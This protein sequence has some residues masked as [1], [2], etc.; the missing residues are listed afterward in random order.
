[1]VYNIFSHAYH[2]VKNPQAKLELETYNKEEDNERI[3]EV[4]TLLEV[5]I[6]LSSNAGVIEYLNKLSPSHSQLPKKN[7]NENEN[8]NAYI[9][10]L[11]KDK[12]VEFLSYWEKSDNWEGVKNKLEKSGL[13]K[14]EFLDSKNSIKDI[15]VVN[16][17]GNSV[18]L[19]KV[20]EIIFDRRNQLHKKNNDD[21][22]GFIGVIFIED[23][24]REETVKKVIE[25]LQTADKKFT[26][27]DMSKKEITIQ[28]VPNSR[29][30]KE[31][32]DL[33]GNNNEIEATIQAYIENALHF[34]SGDVR[35]D[36]PEGKEAEEELIKMLQSIGKDY[37]ITTNGNGI[38]KSYAIRVTNGNGDIS[39]AEENHHSEKEE[40]FKNL[41]KRYNEN[42]K[43]KK[44]T[45][46]DQ[47]T[48]N[49]A[50]ADNILVVIKNGKIEVEDTEIEE[51]NKIFEA[52]GKE[53]YFK[54]PLRYFILRKAGIPLKD[55]SEGLLQNQIF[56]ETDPND[57]ISIY[58]FSD[59]VNK[60]NPLSVI[61]LNSPDDQGT[62]RIASIQTVKA[63][64]KSNKIFKAAFEALNVKDQVNKQIEE[65]NSLISEMSEE[66][67]AEAEG[68]FASIQETLKLWHGRYKGDMSSDDTI[69]EIID[70]FNDKNKKMFLSKT[71]ESLIIFLKYFPTVSTSDSGA[72]NIEQLSKEEKLLSDIDTLMTK[73]TNAMA[74]W[75]ESFK[76][77]VDKIVD[78]IINKY[79]EYDKN[80]VQLLVIRSAAK[81][82]ANKVSKT[83]FLDF[84]KEK[85]QLNFLDKEA[86]V[87]IKFLP[88]VTAGD[89][90]LRLK[91]ML[92]LPGVEKTAVERGYNVVQRCFYAGWTE[93]KLLLFLPSKAFAA[94]HDNVNEAQFQARATRTRIVKAVIGALAAA[95]V[96]S[97]ALVLPWTAPGLLTIIVNTAI[98]SSVAAAAMVFF[99]IVVHAFNNLLEELFHKKLYN[100]TFTPF[101][102]EKLDKLFD[103][104]N[105]L[106]NPDIKSYID[107][108]TDNGDEIAALF[109][110]AKFYKDSNR[111]KAK[112]K[113][114]FERLC[115]EA[116]KRKKINECER[117]ID[118]I[119][120]FY[121]EMANS[122]I[123]Q[124]FLITI[125]ANEGLDVKKRE[126][127]DFFLKFNDVLLEKGKIEQDKPALFNL[128][129][130]I[131]DVLLTF[132]DED[133]EDEDRE[134][135]Y[136]RTL[137]GDIVYSDKYSYVT[138]QIFIGEYIKN[139]GSVPIEYFKDFI[140][141]DKF[142][143]VKYAAENSYST[144]YLFGYLTDYGIAK[145]QFV[146]LYIKAAGRN[147]KWMYNIITDKKQPPAFRLYALFTLSRHP[148]RSSILKSL[149]FKDSSYDGRLISEET[150]SELIEQ[151]KIFLEDAST[152]KDLGN[153][154]L[155]TVE[156]EM[157]FTAAAVLLHE[158]YPNI[159]IVDF[160][161]Q[162]QFTFVRDNSTEFIV[163]YT[164][165]D[166]SEYVQIAMKDKKKYIDSIKDFVENVYKRNT[167]AKTDKGHSAL[168][169]M[170]ER[171]LIIAC[172]FILTNLFFSTPLLNVAEA[173]MAK[174]AKAG[175]VLNDVTQQNINLETDLITGNA[176]TKPAAAF[177]DDAAEKNILNT[178][179]KNESVQTE[180]LSLQQEK[181][182]SSSPLST[183]MS[184]FAGLL[185]F[186]LSVPLA[187]AAAFK[188]FSSLRKNIIN[189]SIA[190]RYSFVKESLSVEDLKAY[191]ITDKDG[192]ITVPVF[193]INKMPLR[194]KDFKFKNT[195]VKIN[196]KSVWMSAASDNF[197]I[198][199]E[200]AGLKEIEDTLKG[201][202]PRIRA[203]LSKLVKKATGK[204]LDAKFDAR[205][206][207]MEFNAVETSFSYEGGTVR[208][209]LS[210]EDA[211]SSEGAEFTYMT[212]VRDIADADAMAMVENIYYFL[213]DVKTPE[214]L[215]KV[216]SDFQKI[217]NGQIILSYDVLKNNLDGPTIK[218][219]FAAARRNGIKIIADHRDMKQDVSA[220]SSEYRTIGFDGI[221]YNTSENKLSVY[222][223]ALATIEEASVIEGYSGS[224][225]LISKLRQTKNIKILNNSEIVRKISAGDSSMV[226]RVWIVRILK[227]SAIFDAISAN[228]Y[229]TDTV[230]RSAYNL[231][232][233]NFKNLEKIGDENL[234][235]LLNLLNVGNIA[236]VRN[237]LNLPA[238]HAVNVYL[239]DIVRNVKDKD[240]VLALQ[241]AYL[242][243]IF[244]KFLVN[245]NVVGDILSKTLEKQ[246]GKALRLQTMS[247]KQRV[248]DGNAILLADTFKERVRQ[249]IY[250]SASN[251]KG[252]DLD[253][254][255]SRELQSRLAEEVN[256]LA[257]KAFMSEDNTALSAIIELIPAIAEVRL[258]VGINKENMSQ[259][260]V[261][262][263]KNLLSAA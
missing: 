94:L 205:W 168:I 218:E 143:A 72:I 167:G 102:A 146:S 96:A 37:A 29:R 162:L 139:V 47:P 91:L 245:K 240:E 255:F 244:E 191:R 260:D 103:E 73:E 12:D 144:K 69:G 87:G 234:V 165:S 81:K 10:Q 110:N 148:Y 30:L 206:F 85:L 97:V 200:G 88:R 182:E 171:T 1:I 152:H 223:F 112:M 79:P 82:L 208:A 228:K 13:F 147:L 49:L 74:L 83:R 263:L 127:L 174:E 117:L 131:I 192:S 59:D 35:K 130:E 120:G 194:K 53:I 197:V 224:Q 125:A 9:T 133:R 248:T 215:D 141:D 32:K 129:K 158:K 258:N 58:L 217:G 231:A 140:G 239:N 42:N 57:K 108:F 6:D 77:I 160:L 61:Y 36:H 90:G 214:D 93:L 124:A 166:E 153:D 14:R 236:A 84:V 92:M 43:D 178:L 164:G 177:S 193:I 115:L 259:F 5:E 31:L 221:L 219:F 199:A 254:K 216:L 220:V 145:R 235:N 142:D 138:K 107:Q 159:D 109:E 70:F 24:E 65:L 151:S 209:S 3:G 172:I 66:R 149:L 210:A 89:Y 257:E 155:N 225:E 67:Y 50:A 256:A 21:P 186:V 38:G 44:I 226:D 183:V 135:G 203:E 242:E 86:L 46:T 116:I 246:L 150:L 16:I 4:N 20:L 123:F 33:A 185:A 238:V 60:K 173:K 98:L 100:L 179:E 45:L 229:T 190:V 76:K 187:L 198:F 237:A 55:L 207:N 253:K 262:E 137:A 11:E 247:G 62:F 75:N 119:Y 161:R 249:Q 230:K 51:V 241:K 211:S 104:F 243:G 251:L 176:I 227:K 2:N 19:D 213:D 18:T 105:S 189:N 106:E 157:F 64:K 41:I 54:T 132:S 17:E 113:I 23:T 56:I 95:V 250:Q 233:D 201:D 111:I 170:I 232:N 184:L 15:E 181:K 188:A 7:K 71:F 48:Q 163:K 122:N 156:A 175:Y 28:S 169:K 114:F 99:G 196:G 261:R 212:G 80:I 52:I 128:Q 8:E 252:A 22:L 136:V 26:V 126:M 39:D 134:A 121:K 25:I 27:K 40:A 118:F 202:N 195:G 78:E 180:P 222:D 101:S 34:V 204:T 68:M 154:F 63:T